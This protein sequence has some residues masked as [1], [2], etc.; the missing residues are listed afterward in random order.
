MTQLTA[1][2]L[3]FFKINPQV[4]KCFDE[5]DLLRLGES[6]KVKQLQP[7]LAQPD[8]T[9][10]AGERRFRAAKLVGLATLEVIITEKPLSE[11]EIR[12]IQLTENIQRA[13]LSGHEKWQGCVEL[14]RMNQWQQKALAEHLHLSESAVSKLLS[15]SK[16]SGSWQEALAAGRVGI[17]DCYAAS[18]LPEADQAALLTLKLSGANRDAIVHAGRKS[19][20]GN[21]PSVKVTRVKCQ[22]PSGVCIVA[23]GNG[24]SL[25]DLIESLGEAQKEAKKARD[26]GLDAKTFQSVMKDKSKKRGA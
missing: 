1:K 8:G 12:L 18:G 6:M 26:Q 2:P 7:V 3:S 9:L 4:R 11:T 15:P 22:L 10:I 19:R 14:V 16:C 21:T 5:A 20:N 17:S 25:D 24:L 13:S 23:S